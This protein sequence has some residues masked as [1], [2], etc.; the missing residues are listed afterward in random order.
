[1]LSAAGKLLGRK[2]NTG[3]LSPTGVALLMHMDDA[4]TT[5]FTDVV[6]HSVIRN[7]SPVISDAWAG[8]FGGRS[9]LFSG[10]A[11]NFL[12]LE[13]SADWAFGSGDFTIEVRINPNSVTGN[14]N[15]IGNY[16]SNTV[17][18][19]MLR[20][21]GTTVVWYINGAALFTMNAAPAMQIGVPAS[22]AIQ[23]R[24]D[25]C[26]GYIGGNLNGTARTYSGNFGTSTNPLAIG[27]DSAGANGFS[28]YIDEVRIT[29]AAL[30]TGNYTPEVVAFPDP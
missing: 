20:M 19:W 15:I 1:M 14:Q 22:L 29:K 5:Q 8:A 23:R 18:H 2:R 12:S 17:G 13:P 25:Q 16:I 21:Q 27:G 28:G 6:G 30:Y 24:G 10:A 7:G 4:V 11:G 26:V 3:P 9:A